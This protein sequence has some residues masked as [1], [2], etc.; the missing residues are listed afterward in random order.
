MKVHNPKSSFILKDFAL[1]YNIIG[2]WAEEG[3]HNTDFVDFFENCL[4]AD[5][6]HCRVVLWK[7]IEY[8]Y[9]DI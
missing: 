2:L 8:S 4:T 5:L 7:S 1:Y 9:V 6:F 3:E